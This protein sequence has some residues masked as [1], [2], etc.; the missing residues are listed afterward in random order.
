MNQFILFNSD[1]WILKQIKNLFFV[2][3]AF[4]Y[5][6]RESEIVSEAWNHFLDSSLRIEQSLNVGREE[7]IFSD[8]NV[9]DV[10]LEMTT[11]KLYT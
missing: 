11:I 8:E 10:N 2:V 7:S 9:V 4:E 6:S 1:W 5:T 3:A